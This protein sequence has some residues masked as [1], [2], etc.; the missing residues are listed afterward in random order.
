VA[1]EAAIAAFHGLSF[2]V[3]FR[4]R[5]FEADTAALLFV[6]VLPTLMTQCKILRERVVIVGKIDAVP[7][8]FLIIVL[9]GATLLAIEAVLTSPGLRQVL[10]CW[11]EAEGV[12]RSIAHTTEHE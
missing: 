11:L 10:Y 12:I 9:S 3:H 5:F 1:V 7:H 2:A 8:V 6:F 4:C